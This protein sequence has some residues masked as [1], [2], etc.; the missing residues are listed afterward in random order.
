MRS[1]TFHMAALHS[2]LL[3]LDAAISCDARE[4]KVTQY[5]NL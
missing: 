3:L 1:W 2:L 4:I 5:L